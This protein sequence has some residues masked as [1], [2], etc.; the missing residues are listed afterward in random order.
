MKRI[1][2]ISLLYLI[3]NGLYAQDE[4]LQNYTPSILFGKG[5]YE[6]KSFQNLFESPVDGGERQT[7]FTSIN[8]FLYGVNSQINV[9]FD[10]WVHSTNRPLALSNGVGPEFVRNGDRV[11]QSGISLFGPKIKIA[12]FKGLERL[13]IQSSYLFSTIDD[14]ENKSPDSDRPNFF[15]SNDRSIWLTQFFYD[16]P[17]SDKFQLFFQQ[18]FWY[19]NVH[20]S[21]AQNNFLETQSSVFFSYFADSRWTLYGMTE[22]FPTHYNSGEQTAEA[23][24]NWFVQSGLGVKYQLIPGLIELETLYTNFWLGSE[25]RDVGQ[26]FNFGIRLIN[27]K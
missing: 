3:V 22:Y 26:T 15:F 1:A 6:F 7:F 12:P 23:F 16:L 25:G 21:F 24:N 17:V 5:D 19:S 18:A 20:D 27:Q 13:S 11:T 9:G 14:K 10:L 2:L 8:Q 4:N